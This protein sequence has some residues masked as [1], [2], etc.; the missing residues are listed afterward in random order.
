MSPLNLLAIFA[1]PQNYP[2]FIAVMTL[3][4]F[5]L[6]SL[7]MCFYLDNKKIKPLNIIIFSTI[8][9]LMGYSSTY[10]YNYIWI[11]SLI[12]LPL[13]IHGLDRILDNKSPTFYIFTLTLTIIINYYIGYMICIF[14]L[15]WFI[16]K[17]INIKERK[18]IT[19][20]F[21]MSS[22]L[23]G[24]MCMFII[25]PS[26][27]ALLEGKADLYKDINYFSFSSNALFIPYFLSTG[28]YSN[29]DQIN[30]PALIYSGILVL[31]L[32]IFYFYNR[33]FSKK[34]KILEKKF[35]K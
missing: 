31:V 23:S 21:L 6:M 35:N 13:V 22:I 16:H 15:I 10:Y 12:M 29:G 25:I 30:G 33:S 20:T 19:K 14:C 9:T 11:D 3:I 27:Y 24:I 8:Y 5:S 18:K 17:I 1:T 26:A 28:S 32:S 34:E 7:S 4:R 2:Y